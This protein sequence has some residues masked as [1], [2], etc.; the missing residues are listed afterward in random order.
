[1]NQRQISF[2]VTLN[3]CLS[4]QKTPELASSDLRIAY[5]AATLAEVL[6]QSPHASEISLSQLA[7]FARAAA[8]S[9]EKSHAELVGLIERAEA[10]GAGN[11]GVAAH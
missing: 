9:G 7:I 3:G 10:M 8:R 11:S 6:R 5:S 4:K 1:M 2:L